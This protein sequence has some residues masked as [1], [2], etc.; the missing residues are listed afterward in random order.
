MKLA[1]LFLVFALLVGAGTTRPIVQAAP[2]PADTKRPLGMADILAW[3]TIN[4]A[5]VSNDGKWL[6]YRLAP[7]EGDS[8]V[9]VRQTAGEKEYRFGVGET[10]R[11]GGE[12]LF[13]DDSRWVA[14]SV[15][16]TKKDAA[17][18][19]KQKKPLQNKLALVD[20]ATGKDVQVAKVRRFAFSGASAAWLAM[21]KYGADGAPG[22]PAGPGPDASGASDK[23]K[24]TDLILHE[25]ATGNELNIGNVADFA[26]DKA[27]RWI[28][29]TIDA[30]DQDGN[31]VAVRQLESGAVLPLDSGKAWYEKPTWTEKGEALAVLKGTEDKAYKD[32]LYAV[33]GFTG[34]DTGK[35]AKVAYDPAG[36]KTFPAAMSISPDRAPSWMD[37]HKAIV[38]GIRAPK[39]KEDKADAPKPGDDKAAAKDKAEKTDAKEKPEA[40]KPGLEPED[41]PDLVLWHY[42]D[43]RL[44]SQQ[45]VE[46]D[47]DKRFSYAALY[48]VDEKKFVRLADDT[49][50]EVRVT[51]QSKWGI[52]IDDNAYERMAGMDGRNYEDVYAVNLQTGE[53]KP[54][55]KKVRW[56]SGVSP[57]ATR[58]LYFEDGHYFA[59]DVAS[60][61]P[62]NLTKG[63]P[64]SFVDDRDD[65][66]VVKPPTPSLG[67]TKDGSAV[68]LSDGWDL[69]LVPV[70]GTGA[71]NLTV[72]GRKDQV[73][74]QRRFVL[75]PD[76][77]G[78]DP[79]KPMYVATYGEWTKKGGVAKVERAKPGA[80]SLLWDDAA[81]SRVTKAKNAD[82]FVYSRETYNEPPD[83][84]ATDAQL[85]GGKKLTALDAQVAKY[86][87]S[88]GRMLVDYKP[89]EKTLKADKLQAALFLPAN[90]EKGKSYPTIVYIYERLSQGLNQFTTPALSGSGFNKSYYTSQGYAVLMPDITYKLNDPG[91]SAAWCILPALKA[92]IATGVVDAKRVGLQGH[93]WGGYQTAF[94]V[95]QTGA[96]AAAVAG[97]PLTDMVSMYSLI[98]KNSGNTNQ[99]IFESS[100]GRFLG[101]YWDNW[102]AYYRNS[103]VFFARNVKTPLMIL[104]NDKDGAVDFT[105]GVEYFNTLRRLGKPV[106]MLEYLGE[107][108]GL[109][110]P[111]NMKDYMVR[112]REFFDVHLMGKPLPGWMKDGVSRIDMDEHLKA[113][114]DLLTGKSDERPAEG[115]AGTPAKTEPKPPVK[116]PEGVK[117]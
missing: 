88:A 115:A 4:A 98:Y 53:K 86:Q 84:Y 104:H 11:G 54:L 47:R 100:Q 50:R 89:E 101:G 31:G 21:Q 67:W 112:M 5:V 102:E 44:Q 64:V 6:A 34:F 83:L 51:P 7:T 20:L 96:F 24:G 70:T 90:Y 109:A 35:P 55:V 95:T 36:D 16:P 33:V 58:A 65:H 3:K 26:F 80:Q 72:T 27:G 12:I 13:S 75:D 17:Q 69:W 87:W 57:D 103:P 62:T 10:G 25:L 39:K 81:F 46:E 22:L 66:N 94:M 85:K 48:R 76:E 32:K 37:D 2:E 78:L 1:R 74:Y 61:Q 56:F 97:A 45:Q 8:E 116:Q 79:D 63:I 99:G 93:S 15:Y 82:V 91:R 113:R 59:V 41:K 23:P 73:R 19:K 92:A 14:F 60:A 42:Q 52:G 105:Q 71:V 106:W 108:H 110:K 40:D 77:K 49:V 18:L 28:A 43:K 114:A 38:F 117:K 30:A 29:W 111:A 68:L 9:I 107:N